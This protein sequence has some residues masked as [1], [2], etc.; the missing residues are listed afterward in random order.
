MR[1][2][3]KKL[4]QSRVWAL[5]KLFVFVILISVLEYFG[6]ILFSSAYSIW[7]KGNKSIYP[8]SCSELYPSTLMVN[9]PVSLHKRL[10]NIKS[11]LILPFNTS[12]TTF[13]V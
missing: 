7:I 10:S 6:Y 5:R 1:R 3:N 9:K 12:S 4:S 2:K 11:H 13:R 8:N